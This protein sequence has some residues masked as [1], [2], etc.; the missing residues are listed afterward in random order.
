MNASTRRSRI[1][2]AL[3]IALSAS[4][5]MAGLPA[6]AQQGNLPPVGSIVVQ[7]YDAAGNLTDMAQLKYGERIFV[8]IR[9]Y[10]RFGNLIPGCNPQLNAI[11]GITGNQLEIGGRVGNRIEVRGGTN[12]GSAELAAS[13]AHDPSFVHKP[14]PIA[15]LKD[16]NP[17]PPADGMRDAVADAPGGPTP[18]GGP[19]TGAALAVG[20]GVAAAAAAVAVAA[21][22]IGGSE[23]SSSSSG[24]STAPCSNV[25][26]I[27]SGFSCS[28]GPGSRNTTCDTSVF[29]VA[30]SGGTCIT[31]NTNNR[32][33]WC[34]PN[35]ACINARCTTDPAC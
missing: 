10:D 22:G 17:K 4:M 20:L 31:T 14:A 1:K 33:A 8:E 3:C 7:G 12:F 32:S 11:Q 34:P 29:P 5:A 30:P 24:P 21:G 25:T 23:S 18:G 35:T 13:C 27:R 15:V 26:C 9:A 19:S 28:C 6:S 2:Q 16:F